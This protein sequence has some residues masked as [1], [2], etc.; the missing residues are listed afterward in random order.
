[1]YCTRMQTVEVYVALFSWFYMLSSVHKILI[2]GDDIINH[3][4]LAIGMISEAPQKLRN[5]NLRNFI[6]QNTRT[7]PRKKHNG[8]F[9]AFTSLLFWCSYFLDL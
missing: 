8:R 7:N 1:M 2:H 3:V 6:E 9:D 5:K 4:S